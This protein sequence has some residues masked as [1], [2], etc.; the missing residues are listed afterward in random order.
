MSFSSVKPLLRAVPRLSA[1]KAPA[2]RQSIRNAS[3]AAAGSKGKTGIVLLG[4]GAAAI[5]SGSFYFFG[6]KQDLTAVK[7]AAMPEQVDYQAYVRSP[8]ISLSVIFF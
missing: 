5:G 8:S 7:D 6:G 1:L 2:F 3:T 4:V